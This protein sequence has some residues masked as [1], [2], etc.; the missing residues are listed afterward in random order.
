MEEIALLG[1][2]GIRDARLLSKTSLFYCFVEV[3]GLKGGEEEEG[4]TLTEVVRGYLHRLVAVGVD[5][6]GGRWN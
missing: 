1:G 5:V 6:G 4:R 2:G 3:V